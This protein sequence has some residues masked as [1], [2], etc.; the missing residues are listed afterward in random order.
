METSHA[1]GA[2]EPLASR[3]VREFFDCGEPALDRFLKQFARQNQDR[4]ASRTFVAVCGKDPKVLGYTTLTVR[5]VEAEHF[6]P[7]E[8]KRFPRYPVPVI[9]LARLAVDRT[10]QGQG[11]GE[12]LLAD[13]IEKAV[14]VSDL[15]GVFAVEVE[16]KTPEAKRFYEKHLFRAFPDE[17][18]HLYLALATARQ[19]FKK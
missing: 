17:A 8:A 5:S 12:I 13:A 3:H 19:L 18:L 4:G 14:L 10:A 16:A 7:E 9:H 2:I 15:V 1:E 11:L 6:P